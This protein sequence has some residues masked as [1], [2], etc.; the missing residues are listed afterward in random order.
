MFNLQYSKWP[1]APLIMVLLFSLAVLTCGGNG[2]GPDNGSGFEWTTAD[3]ADHDFDP[4]LLDTLTIRLSGGSLGRVTSLLIV[5]DGYLIYEQYFRGNTRDNLVSIYSCTKS[6]SAALI[7]IAIGEG[8]IGGVDDRLF[9]YLDGYDLYPEDMLDSLG[10]ESLTLEHLLTMTAG[11]SWEEMDIIYGDPNNSYTQMVSSD[12]WIQFAL[13]Q[14]L[15]SKPGMT[16]EYNTGLSGLMAVVLK[17]STGQTASAYARN[18]LFKHIGIDTCSWRNCPG[19]VPMTGNGLKLRPRDM[20]KFGWLYSQN[21]VWDGDTIVPSLWVEASLDP[22]VTLPS[23]KGYGYQWWMVTVTD[24]Q[25]NPFYMPYALG[26]GGQHIFVPPIAD[27]VIVV[28]ADDDQA[29][30]G[31]YIVDILNLIGEAYQL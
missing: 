24:D 23:G 30:S 1:R 31:S 25:G 19:D 17:N 13:D 5:K 4:D 21:G 22:H 3:P 14:P 7:G 18:K 27:M 2:V 28:T 26:W 29:V 9:D 11:F 16:F 12:D 15:T 8:K 20:A 6:I 10:R